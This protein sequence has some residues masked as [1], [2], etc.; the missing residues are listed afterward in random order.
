[1]TEALPTLAF[2]LLATMAG[3]GVLARFTPRLDPAEQWGVGGL[4]GLAV[5]GLLTLFVGLVP[6]SLGWWP[7]AVW[8]VPILVSARYWSAPAPLPRLGWQETASWL[9]VGVTCAFAFLAVLTPSD[10]RDWDTLAYHLAVPKI[11]L[12]EG[13]I[14]FVQ[15]IHH[16]N[17]PFTIDNLYVLGLR[18]GGEP[19]AKSFAW[20]FLPLGALALFGL[21]RR[22]YGGAAGG[23]AA[24]A[25]AAVPVVAWES[26]TAYIDVA[27]GL[28]AGL[29]VCY[30]AGSLVRGDAWAWPLAGLCLGFTLG[31][32]HTGLQ[33]ALALGAVTLGW[34]LRG[35]D[36]PPSD[37]GPQARR[38]RG[39]ILAGALALVLAFPWY[40]KSVAYTGNPVYPFLPGIFGGREWDKWRA[41]LYAGEQATFGV[42][43]SPLHVGHAVFGLAYNP[44]R[45][46]NP[47][48]TEGRGFPTGSIGFAGLFVGLLWLARGRGPGGL[49]LREG[50]ILATLGVQF[51]M[52]FLLSQQSR[53]LTIVAVPLAV[54]AGGAIV[55]GR[56]KQMAKG[57]VALQ[58]A[59]TLAILWL[60]QV[61]TDWQVVTQGRQA[62]YR[63]R[64]VPF[65]TAAETINAL[66]KGTKVALYD[67]VFGYFLDV[68]YIW[69]NPGH[70]SWIPYEAMESGSDYARMMREKGF[71]HAYLNFSPGIVDPKLTRRWMEAAG[72]APGDPYGPVEADLMH[73][74]LNLWWR[75]LTA[76]AVRRGELRP[77]QAFGSNDGL[78]RALLFEFAR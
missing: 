21:A 8:L 64:A 77:M 56:W 24:L 15:N 1:M 49:A 3:R 47:G 75:Y 50:F 68:G 34:L 61:P 10:A 33:V 23:W 63:R 62:E 20:T 13:Q 66:P 73:S 26:G 54:L 40:A 37:E 16:S 35:P 65:A 18:W 52:W 4:L 41:D 44:G 14:G 11:W 32:K 27:H 46:V 5:V 45:Y 55:H 78:P 12:H 38:F 19:G 76:D 71:T 51:A 30:A 7:L 22:W 29:A 31:S 59:S 39:A 48:Q 58:A 25:F 9:V 57:A 74:D 28:F 36:V 17:F 42:G 69:A 2:A 6:G 60:W 70:S 67:E 53:Y 72:L 43:K